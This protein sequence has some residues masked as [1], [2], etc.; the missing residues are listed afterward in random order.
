MTYCA[1]GKDGLIEPN[2]AYGILLAQ[3]YMGAVGADISAADT[4]LN[5]Q[6][7]TTN[8]RDSVGVNEYRISNGNNDN[9]PPTP[10][11]NLCQATYSPGNVSRLVTSTTA[12][13]A[14]AWFGG[15]ISGSTGTS[16]TFDAVQ[17]FG[18]QANP[19]AT[20]GAVNTPPT[21]ADVRI[22]EVGVDPAGS[23]DNY[24]YIELLKVGGED[25][26]LYGSDYPHN[27]GDMKGC[28]ARVDALPPPV[29]DK[30]RGGNAMR[31]FRL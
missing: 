29:R 8:L 30:V 19:V 23:D 27:I 2:R 22:N 20:P 3:G 17:R 10:V 16:V 15:T 28:L 31:I 13:S 12:N 11:A 25:N 1:A 4:V 24:E 21:P 18:T 9:V 14:A 6:F 5:N 26:V 7:R